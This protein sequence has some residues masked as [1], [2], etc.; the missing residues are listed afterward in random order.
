MS[1][2]QETLVG[3]RTGFWDRHNELHSG[4]LR[5][6][7]ADA[8]ILEEIPN[9]ASLMLI[10]RDADEAYLESCIEV[11]VD[12]LRKGLNVY[13]RYLA[14]GEW[15]VPSDPT[16][17]ADWDDHVVRRERFDPPRDDDE[18]EQ[19]EAPSR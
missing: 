18:A 2:T 7:L 13:F 15:W 12:S 14:P 17:T 8:T 1:A 4:L 19:P 11:G 16:I 6:I 5:A 10:P 3:S 9:G